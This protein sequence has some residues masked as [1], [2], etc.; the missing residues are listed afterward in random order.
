MLKNDHHS[1]MTAIILTGGM[2]NLYSSQ[3]YSLSHYDQSLLKI[4]VTFNLSG[5]LSVVPKLQLQV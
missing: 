3:M 2:Y 5:I 1:D 4:N